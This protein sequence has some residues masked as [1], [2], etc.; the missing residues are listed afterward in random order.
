MAGRQPRPHTGESAPELLRNPQGRKKIGDE[1]AHLLGNLF[2]GLLSARRSIRRSCL[3]DATLSGILQGR[4]RGVE[5]LFELAGAFFK[6]SNIRGGLWRRR[7]GAHGLWEG[8]S[9]IVRASG[10]GG[11]TPHIPA[12]AVPSRDGGA[13][14]TAVVAACPPTAGDRGGVGLPPH[15]PLLRANT[16]LRR[17]SSASVE[18]SDPL[19]AAHFRA[20]RHGR[21]IRLLW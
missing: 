15:L 19:L 1:A 17:P 8:G 12:E 4:I 14:Q 6:R 7:G 16:Q 5:L 21:C 2:G 3:P 18:A 10:G 13:S 11:G 20:R 9:G